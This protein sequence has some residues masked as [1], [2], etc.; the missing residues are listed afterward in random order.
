MVPATSVSAAVLTCGNCTMAKVTGCPSC[1]FLCWLC[2]WKSLCSRSGR[3]SRDWSETV[4][5]LN[6]GKW[7]VIRNTCWSTLGRLSDANIWIGTSN[8]G[9]KS[10]PVSYLSSQALRSWQ[11]VMH[12][13][14]V[15]LFTVKS[16]LVRNSPVSWVTRLKIHKEDLVKMC[17]F[18]AISSSTY[19]T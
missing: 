4:I 5:P 12:T 7:N 15:V 3:S 17:Y 18:R 11:P 10:Y 14:S 16:F 6:R 13:S 1:H 8:L 2:H 9:E 19:H